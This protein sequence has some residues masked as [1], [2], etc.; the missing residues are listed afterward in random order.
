MVSC[1]GL[2]LGN[3]FSISDDSHPVVTGTGDSRPPDDR[4]DGEDDVVV[5]SG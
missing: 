2:H 5:T 1:L 3:S 4:T